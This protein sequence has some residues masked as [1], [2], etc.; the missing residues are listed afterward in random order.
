MLSLIDSKETIDW[1]G[2]MVFMAF[3]IVG[4][5]AARQSHVIYHSNE[6]VQTQKFLLP[7]GPLHRVL[8]RPVGPT[9]LGGEGR[10]LSPGRDLAALRG[11]TALV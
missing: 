10:A 7:I 11:G 4:S 5:R 2:L 1:D 9:P 8:D 6:I 3:K